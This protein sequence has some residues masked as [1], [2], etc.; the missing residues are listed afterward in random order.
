MARHL[1]GLIGNVKLVELK[2]RGVDSA[3]GQLAK[4][5]STRSVW[6]A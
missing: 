1:T 2:V 3:L 6:L 4:R 5:L